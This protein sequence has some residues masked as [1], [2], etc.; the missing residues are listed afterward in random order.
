M[1]SAASKTTPQAS[2]V[3]QL[4]SRLAHDRQRLVDFFVE[5]RRKFEEAFAALENWAAEQANRVHA[6]SLRLKSREYELSLRLAELDRREKTLSQLSDRLDARWTD[7]QLLQ[8]QLR[9]QAELLSQRLAAVEAGLARGLGQLED[10]LRGWNRVK[11]ELTNR[12]EESWKSSRELGQHEGRLA[13]WQE[14]LAL[15]EKALA[16]KEKLVNAKELRTQAQ[17]H[18]LLERLRRERT[19]RTASIPC[20]PSAAEVAPPLSE[21]AAQLSQLLDGQRALLQAIDKLADSATRPAPYQAATACPHG[22]EGVCPDGPPSA[23]LRN[24]GEAKAATWTHEFER[25]REEIEAL[26]AENQLLVQRVK[27]TEFALEEARAALSRSASPP[28]G[29]ALSWEEQKQLLLTALAQ[30]ELGYASPAPSA[31]PERKK[32]EQALAEAQALLAEKEREILTLQKL[33]E[34]QSTHL[35][36]LALGAAAIEELVAKDEIIQQERENARRLREEWEAKLRQAEVELSLERAKL[37]RERAE[38]EE[39]ARELAELAQE[40]QKKGAVATARSETTPA[41]PDKSLRRRWFGQLGP[42]RKPDR[43]SP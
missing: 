42:A 2:A 32:L 33:L 40:L 19:W 41:G 11:A 5:Q 14:E 1:E 18:A 30:E 43:P 34:E 35:G 6:W 24:S 26:R 31:D 9:L 20:L 12:L 38:L 10:Q 15:R 21:I 8:D 13:A 29:A 7:W 27:D 37:A 23:Q 4:I 28:V 39:R 17:R 22:L 25:A 3:E 36:S 16:E